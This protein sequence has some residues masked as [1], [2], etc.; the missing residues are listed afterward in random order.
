VKNKTSIF[1]AF[2]LFTVL[3]LGCQQHGPAWH[4]STS[5][6]EV[7]RLAGI[8]SRHEAAIL[9]IPGV[10][11]IGI[12][13]E[14]DQFVFRI[15]VAKE[16]PPVK[17]PSKIEGVPVRIVPIGLVRALS[18]AMGTST[19]NANGCYAGTLGLR[20]VDVS[21]S[22]L[23]GYVTNNHVAVKG[24]SPPCANGAPIGAKQY[25]P[26]GADNSCKTGSEIGTLNRFVPIEF[27]TTV[28]NRV[29]AAFV[30]SSG[31]GPDDTTDCGLC[32]P[33]TMV[34]AP[35][36]ILGGPV[37][38]CGRTT[39]LTTG[40]V[41]TINVTI[42]VTYDGCGVARFDKQM[43]VAGS[44][45]FSDHGDSGSAVYAAN[46]IVGLLFAGDSV[47]TTFVNPIADVFNALNVKSGAESSCAVSGD[48]STYGGGGSATA[49]R[50]YVAP[51]GNEML[52]A[53]GG[54]TLL[55]FKSPGGSGH[56]LFAID[57][58]R[59]TWLGRSC[60]DYFIGSQNFPAEIRDL[61][62]IGGF[63]FVA[64]A[65]GRIVKVNGT[66]GS[67]QNMFA[68]EVA[69]NGFS[70]VA[71]YP[72][73]VG[74]HKFSSA[75]ADVTAVGSEMLVSFDDGRMIKIAGTGGSGFN[76]FAIK[77]NGS[78]YSSV[79]DYHYYRGDQDLGSRITAVASIG[80]TLLVATA[81]G[82]VLKVSGTG[83]GGHNMFAVMPTSGGYNRVSPYPYYIGD[84]KFSAPVRRL[85]AA[86]S[87]TILALNDGRMLKIANTG[88]TGHNMFAVLDK[89]NFFESVPNYHYY[90]GD[91][92][93][94]AAATAMAIVEGSLLVGFG[95]GKMLKVTGTGGTGH[96]M[97]AVQERPNGF[98][99]VPSYPYLLGST[100]FRSPVTDVVSLAGF[101]W[102]AIG[103]G[104]L[105][106][107]NGSGGTGYNMFAVAQTSR[108]FSGLCNYSYF[109]GSQGFK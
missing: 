31:S 26:G 14:G 11:G 97:F 84:Q 102:V 57:K 101:T 98:S 66:G 24:R 72:Y 73:Y 100:N 85:L 68:I 27:S 60:Y 62:F 89:R 56:N 74:S 76:L 25:S 48:D 91:Q 29:D 49:P 5:S 109:V 21:N 88:G 28:S 55:K 99:T 45:P 13:K 69:A 10:R 83:G 51:N 106:K 80:G 42:S 50:V 30:T 38:K 47:G 33:P 67:G 22:S 94:S 12:G 93:L 71:P 36:S 41:T 16:A 53:I 19:S 40:T 9:A 17:M 108:D 44:Q 65:D 64:L 52:V 32:F 3:P 35:A 46:G 37:R 23:G 2:L 82:K 20:V 34:I 70:G 95:N 61:D 79:P 87:E 6:T 105:L 104:K 8:Q 15:F 92:K 1:A 58:S 54:G 7:D 39:H 90:I 18:A 4:V 75:I 43:A 78:S 96:N 81:N 103:N 63:T 107:I 86:P 77:D 59:G